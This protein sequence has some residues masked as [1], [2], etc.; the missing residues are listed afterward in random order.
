MSV[1]PHLR[2][3]ALKIAAALLV[4]ISAAPAQ[5][6]HFKV[7]LMGGQSNM[8]G[9]GTAPTSLPAEL[10]ASQE[11]VRFYYGTN[12]TFLEPGSGGTWGSEITFG[13]TIADAF[14]D[15][16]FHFI[17]YADGGTS[18]WNEWNLINGRSYNSLKDIT[19]SGL[20][21]LTRAG[22][23]YEIVGMLWSQGERDAL[24][25][26][27]T[28]QYEADF[29][30]FIADIRSRYGADLPFLF[31]RL[32]VKQLARPIE[33]VRLAQELVAASDP[34][35]HMIDA[36]D[37]G[38]L[39]DSLHYTAQ[40][41]IDM[42][43][44]FAQAYLNSL[45][46]DSTAPTPDPPAPDSGTPPGISSLSPANTATG[47]RFNSKLTVDF[48]KNISF[49]SGSIT[50]RQ[51]GGTV[52]ETYD[53][54]SPP[55]NLHLSGSTLTIKPSADL[56]P[57]TG[58]FIE[59]DATAIEDTDGNS[60]A[61]ISGDSTWAFTTANAIIDGS[62]ITASAS[63]PSMTNVA[64]NFNNGTQAW[65]PYRTINGSGLT[66]GEHGSANLTG[67]LVRKESIQGVSPDVADSHIQ[68]DLGASYPLESIRIWNM[69]QNGDIGSGIRSVDV[70]LSNVEFPG[71]PEGVGAE[72]WTKL[73]DA[74]LE[75]PQA[76]AS[77]NT[78]F[79]LETATSTSLPTTEVRT[80]R[81]ELN[82]NWRGD[83]S[84]T[85]L[86]EIQF[87]AATRGTDTTPPALTI[88]R[89][90]H[91]ATGVNP[92]SDL[93]ITFTEEIAL[94]TGN[95]RLL[96]SGGTVVETFD[97]ASP[98]SGLTV[99]G[100]T[101]ILN[102]SSLLAGSTSYYV[103]IDATAITDLV[104]NSFAGISGDG[105]W[106]F[107]TATADVIAPAIA[108]QSPRAAATG[109]NP[110]TNLIV[111]FDEPIA[112]G[113]GSIHLREAGGV[114]VQSFDVAVPSEGLTLSNN[115]LTLNPS[116][117]LDDSTTYYIE[118]DA[119]AIDDL[120]GNS[121]AGLSGAGAWSFT[122]VVPDVTA[123]DIASTNPANGA[124]FFPADNLFVTFDEWI[125]FGTGFIHIRESDGTLVESF[126]VA[127]PGSK[128]SYLADTVTINPTNDLPLG[129]SYYVE[130]ENTAIRDNSGNHYPGTVGS[131]IWNFSVPASVDYTTITHVGTQFDIESGTNDPTLGWRNPSPAKPL[132]IDGDNILGTDGYRTSAHTSNPPYA[133]TA[134]LAP[135]ENGGGKVYDDPT[136]PAGDDIGLAAFHDANA[137][138]GQETRPL[139]E[140]VIT[141]DLPAGTTLRVGVL[142]DLITVSNGFN[143]ATYT[144]KQTFGGTAVAT[145]PALEWNG[146][147]MDVVYFDLTNVRKTHTYVIT[148]TT[149]S[150]PNHPGAFEQV[151]GV[152]FDTGTTGPDETPPVVS[153][154]DPAHATEDVS[155]SA[156][157]SI[158]FNEDVALGTGTITLR[159]SGGALVESFDVAN[160]PAGLSLSGNTITINPTNDFANSTTYYIEIDATA[161]DDMAG[162]SF[163]GFSGDGSWR[164]T[165]VAADETAPLID[166][167]SPAND[168]SGVA[169][170]SN[171]T[172][173]FTEDIAFGTGSI[174]LRQSGGALVE[175][176][177]VANPPAGL[178]LNGATITIDPTSGLSLGTS[179]Y[180]EID[181]SAID[182][183][184]GNSFAG[185][186]GDGTWGFTTV[187]PDTTPPA[188]QSLSPANGATNIAV[189]SNLTITFSE[190][191]AFGTGSITLRQS[192]GALVE[193]FD[194]GTP[195]PR[196]NL[197]GA[198]L[199]IDPT[200]N[201]SASTTYYLEIAA[202]AIDDLA[203]NS[204]AGISGSGTWG[205]TTAVQSQAA[206]FDYGGPSTPV[207]A[208]FTKVSDPGGT[209]TSNGITIS[210]SPDF[211]FRD[212]T[213]QINVEGFGSDPQVNL[214]SDIAFE[215][216]SSSITFTLTGLTP[217][218]EYA[219]VGYAYDADF[220]NDSVVNNWTT[221]GGTVSHG[222]EHED[223]TTAR[224]EM[225]N[226][227][228]DAD[229]KAT[230]IG[231]YS[232]ASIII[233][234]GFEIAALSAPDTTPPTLS[235]T[236][237]ADQAT[238]VSASVNLVATFDE[239]IA[240]ASG[241]VTIRNLTDAT[242]FTIDIIDGTQITMSGTTLT[243]NPTADLAEGKDY[244]VRIAA[245]AIEDTSGNAF[246]GISDDTTWRFSTVSPT[247]SSWIDGFSG[248]GGLTALGDD[249]DGDGIKNGLENFFGTHPGE[250]SRGVIAGGVTRDGNTT[251]TFTHPLNGSPAANLSAAYRWSKDLTSFHGDGVSF[252]GTTVTFARGTPVDGIVTV[253]A[254]V[255]GTPTD[256]LFIDI[257]VSEN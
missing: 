27:T 110:S 32:S 251:L 246:A 11:D 138:N 43:H 13:R 167:L 208:D 22:H 57:T 212:R 230:I 93:T 17:K 257:T 193:S 37:F 50:L 252:E 67:W 202:T 144:M 233:W 132:D 160:P 14:P 148:S 10:Q 186:S 130:I 76:P 180:V 26:R 139:L 127:N 164:F 209:A 147:S 211:E 82:T 119:T 214:L 23:T 106:S 96:Q 239:G 29:K 34:N 109:V 6:K 188:I 171:L 170:D 45:S 149:V 231:S 108:F 153:A 197:S 216:D 245:T 75:F 53:V 28:A 98:A 63:A 103:E 95:I 166:T 73:G 242:E 117:A 85:G 74:S 162:N 137:G 80:I 191:V 12:Y 31:T 176:F 92:A 234:N 152:T 42:G 201:L 247:F 123:P 240:V 91:A 39:N 102:P 174:T 71:D 175:G 97:V 143:T 35:V 163:A 20:N 204:F 107:A 210:S 38:I 206:R 70:Y 185:I 125:G 195:S 58:Y 158:S 179:Y 4:F 223:I 154:L 249:P 187:L 7:F 222:W 89:P 228:A 105:T 78:G 213:A 253:T 56:L 24:N 146:A 140:F 150:T 59:I 200:A 116:T 226:L 256:H 218:A 111:I 113:S 189:G 64:R 30:A 172:V 118:I 54:A 142:I 254:T 88:L 5:A 124:S 99:S 196:L 248:L 77:G 133:I 60:F 3:P 221:N 165:T 136:N 135:N 21:A 181:A 100:T 62:L 131:T 120:A 83:N 65:H 141:E 199:A 41:Y 15:E 46:G 9:Y 173:T 49:G 217:F 194:V 190:A 237:P 207:Q 169:A 215:N 177:D 44:D 244:A 203:G 151:I 219:V 19:N 198:T 68:W 238:D 155:P 18:L 2:I 205:F 86:S 101:L 69:N 134:K 236:D 159:Q 25:L 61:G 114:I 182:D 168:A 126:D 250:F 229:G 87:T 90:A 79:D 157:L 115:S 52:V 94:G 156:N 128:L 84:F 227:T 243:I 81:F 122:T 51:S 145:T 55:A 66:G 33:A 178:S 220:S 1:I 224:F 121:F 232:V 184:A 129:K 161:I 241:V 183:L 8:F 255:T 112:F 16:N 36:D 104:G 48:T 235:S 72:N 192:G 40:G 225:A 47:V